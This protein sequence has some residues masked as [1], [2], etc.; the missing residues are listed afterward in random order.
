[1]EQQKNRRREGAHASQS[2][3]HKRTPSRRG[4]MQRLRSLC[5]AGHD[6]MMIAPDI[7]ALLHQL[8]PSA[9]CAIFLTQPNGMP[10]AFY[11]EDSDEGARSLFQN[12]PQMFLGGAEHNVFKIVGDASQ[13]KAGGL[14]RPAVEYYSS[15]TYQYLVRPSGHH[16]A[17]EVRLETDHVPA[18]ALMLFREPGCGF[19]DAD[20]PIL[21]NAARYIEFALKAEF[22]HSTAL[23]SID[24]DSA[25]VVITTD[26]MPLYMTDMAAQL[27]QMISLSHNFWQQGH[28]LPVFCLDVV[29]QLQAES[30]LPQSQ[31][32]IPEGL[33]H[34]RAEWLHGV[35]QAKAMVALH[36]KRVIPKSLACWRIVQASDLSPQQADV[37]FL[38]VTGIAKP[39]I[40]GRLGISEAVLKDCI[41]AIYQCYNVHSMLELVDHVNQELMQAA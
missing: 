37:A 28:V 11:H 35:N 7:F 8:I 24:I 10:Y 32:A 41:K 6:P 40:R 17:L 36:L 4:A 16:H 9:A 18:G 23:E 38:L 33:L 1:M 3:L 25:M 20:I 15:N 26:G 19:S 31:I 14:L 12:Q 21:N 27:L 5:C 34:V 2:L 29:R 30:G 22:D 39:V 13:P